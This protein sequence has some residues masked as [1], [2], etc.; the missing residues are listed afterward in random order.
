MPW[1]AKYGRR[2]EW[3]EKHW[4][5]LAE[6]I[7]RQGLD[8]ALDAFLAFLDDYTDKLAGG[9]GHPLY[10]FVAAFD[11]WAP[12]YESKIEAGEDAPC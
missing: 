8:V 6:I 2:P 1:S 10:G 4:Q 9:S 11:K 12:M 3:E 5:K 7:E